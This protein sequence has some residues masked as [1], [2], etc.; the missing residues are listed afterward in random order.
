M[1]SFHA[2]LLHK[3]RTLLLT[4]CHMGSQLS[5][6]LTYPVCALLITNLG[7]QWVFYIPGSIALCWGLLWF[8]VVSD[9]PKT[10]LWISQAEK[11]YI[12]Q[13]L[14]DIVSEEH[15]PVPLQALLTS[16]PLWAIVIAQLG[17]GWGFFI[18]LTDLPLYMKTM[19]SEDINSNALWSSLPYFGGL[20]VM[21][22]S[23]LISDKLVLHKVT[24]RT[25]QRKMAHFVAQLVPAICLFTLTFFD[26]DR[27]LAKVLFIIS[28]SCGGLNLSG[29]LANTLDIAPN[30]TGTV[31]GIENA[32]GTIPGWLAPMTVGALT[33]GQQN[34]AQW[35]KVFYIAVI[36]YIGNM[37]FYLIFGSGEVQSWNAVSNEMKQDGVGLPKKKIS[38]ERRKESKSLHQNNHNNDEAYS[39]YIIN[40]NDR[41]AFTNPALEKTK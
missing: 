28:V 41:N 5:N 24:S 14:G 9:T 33:N 23:A 20:T 36:M 3:N 22:F 34:F 38:V 32:I 19:M 39:A 11:D 1:L 2:G 6:I 37:I 30:F 25:L 12:N 7:W 26:C 29:Y 17:D 13:S 8:I 10:H 21:F 18:M 31:V 40:T 15:P 16:L 35:H 27:D 4:L